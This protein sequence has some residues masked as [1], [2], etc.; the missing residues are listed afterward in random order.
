MS[1]PIKHLEIVGC[2]LL[3][4]TGEDRK[5]LLLTNQQ[6]QDQVKTYF[7]PK[8]NAEKGDNFEAAAKRKT[9]QETGYLNIK[10]IQPISET[11]FEYEKNDFLNIKTVHWFLAVLEDQTKDEAFKTEEKPNQEWIKLPEAI[12]IISQTTSESEKPA[13]K[14]LLSIVE[15]L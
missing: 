10:V 6:E 12:K 13:I 2:V 15:S 8:G 4:K 14:N 7:L 11:T 1:L 9:I 5:V 3:D